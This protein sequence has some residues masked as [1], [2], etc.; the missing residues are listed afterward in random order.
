M[1]LPPSGPLSFSMIATELAIN[2]PYSL[3]SMS[4]QAG[5]STPDAVSEFYGYSG[6][7]TLFFRTSSSD[8]NP[9]FSCFQPCD[10]S[11]WHN[12]ANPLPVIGD[13]VYDDAG[14]TQPI[15]FNGGYW[16]MNSTGLFYPAEQTFT[17]SNSPFGD[18]TDVHIC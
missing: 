6:G 17:T 1:A 13:I 3:N 10:L 16:G 15:M 18:V 9:T 8:P 11:A 5:F 7:L 2:T 14:G 12:G 4:A